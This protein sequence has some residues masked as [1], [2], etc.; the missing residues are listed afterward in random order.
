[1]SKKSSIRRANKSFKVIIIL[2]SFLL[3]GSFLYIYKMSDRSKEIILDLRNEKQ[4][5]IEDFEKN[6]M[7]LKQ[8]M[9]T[10]KNL[11]SKLK[12]EEEKINN[13]IQQLKTAKPLTAK[14]LIVYKKS[15]DDSEGRIKALMEEIEAYKKEIAL[16]KTELSTQ[17][18]KND[19]LVQSNKTLEKKVE[20][21]FEKAGKLYY[22]NL[23][24]ST[25]KEKGSGKLVESTSA[26]RV[27]LIKVNFSIAENDFVKA[28][29]KTFYVQIID[30]KNNVIGSKETVHF[31]KEE[32]TYSASMPVN[33][34]NQT[35]NVQM[36]I[37]VKDLVKG[38]YFIN[39]FDKSKLVL[40]TTMNLD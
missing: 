5:L 27:N 11:S 21:T 1:M 6:K 33:Y 4:T 9:T 28:E 8:L 31:G 25:F 12:E 37:P 2:L 23:K 15:A 40:K 18:Q 30:T 35:I 20:K 38:A 19:T 14:T 13:L 16:T 22:Y 17:K 26:N 39:V 24:S 34:Q 29:A 3:L 32:L 36:E 7:F 10:N